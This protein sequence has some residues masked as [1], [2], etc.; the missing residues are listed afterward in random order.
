M[1]ENVRFKTA[2]QAKYDAL[3]NKNAATLYWC[4]DTQ[5]LYKGDKLFGVGLEATQQFAGLLSAEDKEARRSCCRFYC[6]P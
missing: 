6:W 5:R 2:S 1:A 3:E 4:L